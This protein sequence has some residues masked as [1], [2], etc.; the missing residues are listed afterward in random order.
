[1]HLVGCNVELQNM[2]FVWKET[3]R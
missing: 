3:K 2:L 1:L